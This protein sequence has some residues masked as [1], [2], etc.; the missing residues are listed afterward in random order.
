MNKERKIFFIVV[1]GGHDINRHY[2]ETI[3]NKRTVEEAKQFLKHDEVGKLRERFHDQPYSVWGSVPGE[4]NIRN[5]EAMEAGDYVVVYR[6]GKIILAAEIAMKVRNPSLAEH[7]WGM[8]TNEKTWE[9]IYFLINEVEVNVDQ[10]ELNKYLG[11]APKYFPQGLSRVK[12]DKAN[13]LLFK[14]G[15]LVSLLQRIENGEEPEE[16][17][18]EKAE[19]VEEIIDEEIKKSPTVHDE[20]Q[21]RLIRLGKKANLDVWVPRHD[22]RREYRG[23]RFRDLVLQ[24]FDGALDVPSYIQNIDTVWKLGFSIKS[25]FEIEHSTAIYSG[26]LRLSDLRALAPNSNYPLFIVSERERKTEVFR[27]LKRPTFSNKYLSLDK[28]VKFLSYN[29]VRQLDEELKSDQTGFDISWLLKKA[30]SPT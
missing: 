23:Q 7:F 2:R 6:A 21:W 11:Y 28:A 12:Q 17:D 1:S 29:A 14:Y 3:K 13:R 8:D 27:Q 5:W 20:I 4:N 22:Q 19:K 24:E 9:Y 25:A 15:D 16:I 30:E 10:A 18:V 26:I